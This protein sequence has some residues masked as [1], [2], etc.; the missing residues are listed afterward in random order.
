MAETKDLQRLLGVDYKEH[1]FC[2]VLGMYDFPTA[3]Y[4]PVPLVR[5]SDGKE[6]FG[7]QLNAIKNCETKKM[8]D[9]IE[10]DEIGEEIGKI[11]FGCR[12]MLEIV[13]RLAEIGIEHFEYLE[14][15]EKKEKAEQGGMDSEADL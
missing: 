14:K 15:L 11:I 6:A 1:Q 7:I 12:H 10:D 8:G 4:R 13:K 5:N 2:L 9:K 3:I